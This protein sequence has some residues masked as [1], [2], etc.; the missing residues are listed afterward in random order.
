VSAKPDLRKREIQ[1]IHILK[2]QLGLDDETYRGV[3]WAQATVH[4]STELDGHGR[5]LVI[6]HLEALVAK[7]GRT[8]PK[9]P[10]NT[11]ARSRGELLKIEALLT[12]AGKPWAYAEGMARHMYRKQRLAF[13]APHELRGIVAALERAAL[14]RLKAELSIELQRQGYDWPYAFAAAALLFGFDTTSRDL[15]RYSET[16][17]SVLRWLRGQ[18]APHCERPINPER[19]QCCGGCAKRAGLV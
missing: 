19:P 9:R 14:K 2:S 10:H 6:N 18:L 8:Y 5:R 4:S 13:C 12:D 7:S 3:L 16:M 11:Q 17:S 1:R 15:E